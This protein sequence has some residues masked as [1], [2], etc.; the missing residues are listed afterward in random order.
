MRRSGS[1]AFDQIAFLEEPFPD[2]NDESVR[3]VPIRIVADE[4]VTRAVDATRR[5][6]QGYAGF[7]LKGIAKTLSETI[8]IATL[9]HERGMVCM[10]A[11]LTVNPVLVDW[12]K[13]VAARLAPL[14]GF[15][16]GMMETNGH[17][18]YRRWAE[19]T[20]WHPC[21]AAPW[22]RVEGGVFTARRR[23]LRQE[24]LHLRGV[25]ALSRARDAAEARVAPA[26]CARVSSGIRPLSPH[27]AALPF[28]DALAHA[29]R[30]PMTSPVLQAVGLVR[31]FGGRRAV[32]EVS[33]TLGPGDCLAL[34]GPNGA[35]K[36]TLLRLLAGLLQPSEGSVRVNGVSLK[37][38]A[39]ARAQVGLVSHASMLYGV[40]TVRENVEL[41]ARLYGLA[42][43]PHAAMAA[44]ALMGV[45]DRA[46]APA[47][48][49]SRGLQQRV[50]IARAMVH[51]PR[52]LLCDEPYTGLDVAGSAALTEVL[53]E[54]REAGAAL[55]LVTH[56][57]TEGLALATQAA[58]MRRGRFV[59]H[60]ARELLDP[61]S[62]HSQYRELAGVHD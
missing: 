25:A 23:F 10:A 58:I 29:H 45:E 37:S 7:A 50:S 17:Q 22:R 3:E 21:A 56:N 18:Q 14:P 48:T 4:S 19:M 53:T 34:F 1:G 57:L 20:S 62:Y 24:R 6:Q 32:N 51:A 15:T 26:R 54:R 42:D 49:L 46:D 8:K 47:R 59:R 9:A 41:A 30:P 52:L 27:A 36:T 39:E 38:G 40:L 55:L 11:D 16:T 2:E 44:L 31:S 43:P 12:N 35:G 61:S 13:V 60:E 5:I 33:F 28:H